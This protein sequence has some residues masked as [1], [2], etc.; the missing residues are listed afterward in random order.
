MTTTWATSRLQRRIVARLETGESVTDAI[1]AEAKR[2]AVHDGRVH[3]WGTVE[4]AAVAPFD[5]GRGEFGATQ[6]FKGPGAL[7]HCEG[8]LVT[9]DGVRRLS[10]YVVLARGAQLFGG[11][12]VSA[13]AASLEVVIECWDDLATAV[14]TPREAAHA[15]AYEP[16]PIAS[17]EP[18]RTLGEAAKALESMP[19]HFHAEVAVCEPE[20]GDLLDHPSFGVVEFE[21][22]GDA[23]RVRIKLP[24][25]SRREIMLE[26]F[27]LVARDPIGG[28]RVFGL[29]PRRR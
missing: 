5:V 23:G 6:I 17:P 13:R 3:C 1:Q 7:V 15:P 8:R 4:D 10:A 22:E 18:P 27:D 2:Q 16:E 28:K 26:V 21:S 25:G 24:T 11:Q 20:P 12:L 9:V 19:V 14:E 29:K